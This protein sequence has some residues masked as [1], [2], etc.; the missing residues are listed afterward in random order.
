MKA[1]RSTLSLRALLLAGLLTGAAQAQDDGSETTGDSVTGRQ[2]PPLQGTA[3]QARD[4]E[5]PVPGQEPMM[6]QY[7][8]RIVKGAQ[9]LQT[10]VEFI[11]LC[12]VAMEGL[13]KREY[14]T[15]KQSFAQIQQRWPNYGIGPVG[16]ALV[17]QALML[18]NF[19]FRYDKQYVTSFNRGRQGLEQALLTPGNDTWETFLLGA[20]LG[21]DAIHAMRKEEFVTAINRGLEAMK[22]VARAGE[23]A[24]GFVD[25]ELG[26]GLWL[27]WRSVVA[28]NTPGVPAFSDERKAG[29]A[30][31]QLAQHESV[32]LRPA[33]AHA[34]TYTWLEEG[35]TNRALGIALRLSQ[36]Y[37]NNIV[38]LLVL[39][40]IQ[41]YK[42]L[43]DD[44]KATYDRI[45][46]IDSGNQ[47]VHYYYQRL[48]LRWN[49]LELSEKHA[50]IYL[51]FPDLSDVHRGYA[52]YYKANIYYRRRQWDEAQRLYEE[53][54]RIGKIKSAKDKVERIKRREPEQ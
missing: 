39:G 12:S 11:Y 25:A 26:N 21:V 28:L 31:M 16:Q 9:I 5:L 2:P 34:L 20:L 7:P 54:W 24:P 27:Y 14:E 50:N 33:A 10:D 3:D 51:A 22:Y 32:F 30:K 15:S 23:M 53:A 36:L 44:S 4:L 1:L 42:G 52:L 46:A 48:Y 45:L 6:G 37:P 49:K 43:Y 17:W 19:D 29:I 41:M 13:Y 47:R 35:E 18:E 38:N 8:A 40:R